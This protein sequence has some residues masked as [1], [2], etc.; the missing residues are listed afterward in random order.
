M[1]I[2][3]R[4]LYERLGRCRAKKPFGSHMVVV[5][6]I[7]VRDYSGAPVTEITSVAHAE[8]VSNNKVVPRFLTNKKN[9]LSK[10]LVVF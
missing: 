2:S 1:A 10:L 5:A 4:K 6:N 7:R 3:R 8:L 9:A